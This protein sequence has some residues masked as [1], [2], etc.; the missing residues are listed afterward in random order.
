MF[1]LLISHFQKISAKSFPL[2]FLDSQKTTEIRR[3]KV[4]YGFE[5][6]ARLFGVGFFVQADNV[7]IYLR[8]FFLQAKIIGR[9][10]G[11]KGNMKSKL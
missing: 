4:A 10:A 8:V 6:A 2:R 5:N 11:Q 3:R 7:K 1:S 9:I